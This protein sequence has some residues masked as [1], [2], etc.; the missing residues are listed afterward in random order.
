[1]PCPFQPDVQYQMPSQL[2]RLL[3]KA[4]LQEHDNKNVRLDRNVY[5]KLMYLFTNQSSVWTG[6]KIIVNNL[7]KNTVYIRNNSRGDITDTCVFDTKCDKN[8]ISERKPECS[9][10]LSLK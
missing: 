2:R 9:Q 10:Y 5:Q 6:C 3:V 1:M 8:V 4:D 7:K